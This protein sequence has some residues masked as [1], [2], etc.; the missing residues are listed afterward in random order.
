MISSASILIALCLAGASLE[1]S[2]KWN[3]YN[4]DIDYGS[5]GGGIFHINA[6]QTLWTSYDAYNPHITD[7]LQVFNLLK[8][9]KDKNA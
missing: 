6:Y 1:K 3:F 8:D 2:V 7:S 5:S 4:N 9:G